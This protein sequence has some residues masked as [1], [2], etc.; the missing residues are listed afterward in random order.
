MTIE[1]EV[2]TPHSAGQVVGVH[3]N[4]IRQWTRIYAPLL[5]A[6][7][8]EKP[9][10]YT[11]ADVAMFQAIKELRA[12]D[13]DP[14][15]IIE[16]MRQ[17]PPSELQSPY[18]EGQPAQERPGTPQI[19]DRSSPSSDAPIAPHS[20]PTAVDVSAVMHDLAVLVDSRH[21]RTVERLTAID[22]RLAAIEQRRHG[23]VMLIAGVGLGVL[24]T[25]VAVVLVRLIG[26]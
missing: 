13:I 7:S 19:A 21:D 1:R 20:Q 3:A 12:V 25:A 14:P 11:P 15:S 18:I 9:A 23:L 26:G 16:R 5:S 4:T 24:V 22:E 6:A 2:Y 17:V 8:Q 10:A